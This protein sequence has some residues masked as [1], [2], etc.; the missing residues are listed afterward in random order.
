[1]Q[2]LKYLY[3]IGRVIFTCQHG[4]T[5]CLNDNYQACLLNKIKDQKMQLDLVKCLM[6]STD[7]TTKTKECMETIGGI[8]IILLYCRFKLKQVSHNPT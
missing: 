8:S 7:P 3:V 2:I 5:E 6:G 4:K 1:M